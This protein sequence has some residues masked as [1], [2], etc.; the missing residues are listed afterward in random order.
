MRI[1]FLALALPG[2]ALV[3]ASPAARGQ[4]L[5]YTLEPSSAVT[6]DAAL[7]LAFTGD[8]RGAFDPQTNPGGTRTIAGLFGDPGTNARIPVALTLQVDGLLGGEATGGFQLDLADGAPVGELDG[9]SFDLAPAGGGPA[10]AS[11]TLVLEY[12]TFRTAAPQSVYIGGIALP[13]PLGG[14]DVT[15]VVLVQ[16]AP[17]AA[18]IAP[19]SGAPSGTVE[20]AALVPCELSFSVELGGILGGGGGAP[21]PVGPLPIAVPLRATVD[22]ADCGAALSSAVS[23]DIDETIPS[24]VPL[25]LTDL[26]LDL[27]TILPPGGTANLLLDASLQ[28]LALLGA[29]DATLDAAAP[30]SDRFVDVCDGALNSLGQP[31]ELAPIGTAS[32]LAGDFGLQVTGM[33]PNVFGMLIM[34]RTTDFMPGFGGSQGNLC[35]GEPCFRFDM[36]VA[37]SGPLGE[38]ALFPGTTTPLPGG[39][40]FAAGERWNFQYWYRDANP[41]ATS[42]TS[43]ALGVLFCR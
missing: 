4:A 19:L 1:P 22:L 8:L 10:G 23:L 3:A 29:V 35:V 5:Q 28:D 6:L 21:T 7:D 18:S 26:P 25:D 12:D 43:G 42:N 15:D 14:V 17:A 36:S 32:L 41:G 13:I 9:L 27:P 31:A 40:A 2:L 16:S 34:S 33:P 30:A 20:V 11:L 24:P 38:V 37:S 39:Q